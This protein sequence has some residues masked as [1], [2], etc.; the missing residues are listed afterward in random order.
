M[1]F[2]RILSKLWTTASNFNVE[3]AKQAA[4]KQ[5]FFVLAAWLPLDPQDGGGT[6]PAK[7]RLTSTRLHGVESQKAIA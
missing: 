4:S 6:V 1:Y 3:Y 2:D 5:S 7:L